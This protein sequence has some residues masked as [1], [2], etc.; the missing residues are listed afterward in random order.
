MGQE[1]M[2]LETDVAEEDID[3]SDDDLSD[4]EVEGPMF[5]MRITKQD[6][7]IARRPWRTSLII[8]LIGRKIGYQF[9]LRCL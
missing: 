6:K 9:L 8:K 1:N 7:I 3:R 5:S 2:H 4:D